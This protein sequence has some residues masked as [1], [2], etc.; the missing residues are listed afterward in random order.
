MVNRLKKKLFK[1]TQLYKQ[2][3]IFE[4]LARYLMILKCYLFFKK[5]S[6]PIES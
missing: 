1:K 6:G 2:T 3:H 4:L 5:L